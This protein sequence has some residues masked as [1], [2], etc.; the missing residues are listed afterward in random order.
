MW[1]VL[2]LVGCR[3]MRAGSPVPVIEP[4]VVD[5]GAVPLGETRTA[6]VTV[7]NDGEGA[8]AFDGLVASSEE[9]AVDDAG[10]FELQPG[11]A[12]ERFVSW[13]A[14]TIDN[15]DERLELRVG[16]VAVAW[17]PVIG[18]SAWSALEVS[19]YPIDFEST[20]VGCATWVDRTVH[21]EGSVGEAL[22]A[23]E[24]SDSTFAVTS[25]DGAPLDLPL[26]VA[27]QSS[28]TL[29]IRYA[30]T[31][32]G[33]IDAT[34][35][36]GSESTSKFAV[37]DLHGE[38]QP[39]EPATTT[40]TV[41]HDEAVT[42]IINVNDYLMEDR[43]DSGIDTL[44]LDLLTAFLDSLMNEPEPFRVAIVMH[45]D[46]QVH[47]PVPYID[48]SF[49]L[50]DAVAAAEVMLQGVS[51][52]GDNDQGL[53]TCLRG[54]ESNEDWLIVDSALW[55]D[56]NLNLVVINSDVE[57]SPY[58]ASYYVD[59][60]TEHKRTTDIAVHGIAG[61]A[62]NG[63]WGVGESGSHVGFSPKLYDATVATGGAYLS[64]CEGDWTELGRNLALRFAGRYVLDG[65]SAIE[66]I[67]VFVDGDPVSSGWFYDETTHEITFDD[68]T[69]PPEGAEL[70]VDYA[71][72]D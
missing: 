64:L 54:I 69:E 45:E 3:P 14:S 72:C 53:D 49:S 44:M 21:N 24:V 26:T 57:Q 70:R 17:I 46:G 39:F 25:V 48:A 58:D 36:V 47:G 41:E 27:A 16:D 8:M 52:H 4:S 51:E 31:S 5:F 22:T 66:S 35:V 20:N 28:E 65:A 34:L 59:R 29:R 2:A 62:P 30:P 9:L 68:N 50:D 6:S 18:S 40:W 37:I 7:R 61:D 67:E 63:C 38:A 42:G 15:V 60:Y 55:A 23:I 11:D 43:L 33:P 10:P 56:S 32:E 13:T 19:S 12:H 71:R 1:I